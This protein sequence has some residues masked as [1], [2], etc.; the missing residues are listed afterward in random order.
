MN[1]AE[2]LG[3]Y[4]AQIRRAGRAPA[5]WT[6][7]SLAG[8]RVLAYV[9]PAG[10]GYAGFVLSTDLDEST[11]DDAIAEVVGWFEPDPRPWEWKAYGHDR[12]ADLGNRLLAAGLAAEEVEAL[13]VGETVEVRAATASAALP[14][15]IR[16]RALAAPADLDAVVA[17][18][19]AVWG[20]DHSGLGRDL[21]AEAAAEP[22]S[23]E[24]LL[25]E[26]AEGRLVSA[27]WVRFHAGTD[28]ASLWGG[29]TLPAWRGRG[30]YRAL[31]AHRAVL[32]EDRGYAYLEVDASP[33]S[34]PILERCGMHVLTTTTPYVRR[35]GGSP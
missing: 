1:A 14:G 23:L 5:G 17:L 15:D 27:G 2:V 20:G 22:G 31:V 18:Q 8:G 30:I 35:S 24:I 12:P 4:E 29:A 11:A 33:E 32:A 21:A 16:V 25:A 10:S 7:E 9:P 28:F 34:R 6:V 19:E 3:R 13:V 26:D